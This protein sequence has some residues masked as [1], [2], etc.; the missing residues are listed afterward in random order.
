MW[1]QAECYPNPHA[2]SLDPTLD[3]YRVTFSRVEFLA[4]GYRWIEE[5]AWFVT[6]HYLLWSDFPEHSAAEVR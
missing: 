2:I 5:A 1:Q 4:T 6:G 3:K